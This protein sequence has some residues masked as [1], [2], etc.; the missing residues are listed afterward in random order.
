MKKSFFIEYLSPFYLGGA[1]SA[2]ADINFMDWEF[3][4]II[5]PFYIL[6]SFG[7]K[8]KKKYGK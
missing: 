5:I 3:Y 2:F 1:L 4:A 8:F 6:H 7:L